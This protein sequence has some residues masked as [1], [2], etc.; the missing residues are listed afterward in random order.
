MHGVDVI[1]ARAENGCFCVLFYVS[2][3]V[4][5]LFVRMC[6]L[7]LLIQSSRYLEN[8]YF[9]CFRLC[10][11]LI[12][13]KLSGQLSLAASTI[14]Y[15]VLVEDVHMPHFMFEKLL[16]PLEWCEHIV[17]EAYNNDGYNTE[18]SG[19]QMIYFANNTFVTINTIDVS[20]SN[21]AKS[22][23]IVGNVIKRQKDSLLWDKH[24]PAKKFP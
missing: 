14:K 4:L 20:Y 1:N 15:E 16:L 18:G 7:C 13:V 10:R 22:V 17:Y 2:L 3:D 12:N 6:L 8:L 5:F 23:K 19:K 11:D 24:K 9:D 21:I